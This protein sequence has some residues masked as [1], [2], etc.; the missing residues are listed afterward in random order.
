MPAAVGP[1]RMKQA[2]GHRR[3]AHAGANET[4]L[5]QPGW[6]TWF[7]RSRAGLGAEPPARPNA[8]GERWAKANSTA[9]DAANS[10]GACIRYQMAA[11][12]QSAGALSGPLGPG[13]TIRFLCRGEGLNCLVHLGHDPCPRVV[14]LLLGRPLPTRVAPRLEALASIKVEKDNPRRPAARRRGRPDGGRDF[15]SEFGKGG[16]ADGRDNGLHF[17]ICPRNSDRHAMYVSIG[18]ECCQQKHSV[19]TGCAPSARW[20][21]HGKS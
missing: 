17:S 19:G 13:V 8:T 2:H 21:G 18:V 1:A 15:R 6:R 11:V 4:N 14:W 7:E 10:P 3:P 16:L 9:S 12:S 20:R 5:A